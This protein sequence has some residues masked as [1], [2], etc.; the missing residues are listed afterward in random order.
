[1]KIL[2]LLFMAGLITA[3]NLTKTAGAEQK[4]SLV[5][6][7][8]QI[9]LGQGAFILKPTTVI[10]AGGSARPV[11]QYLADTLAPATGFNL[12]I[13]EVALQSGSQF[14]LLLDVA[15]LDRLGPEGYELKVM[16][17]TIFA[18]AP[19]PRGL[20]YA[21]QTIRQLL[22]PQILSQK[23]VDG[24]SWT[25]PVVEITDK[26]RYSWRGMHL[27]VGR[28]FFDVNFIKKYLDLIALHKM[29]TFHWHLTEDQGWR[30]EIK[31]YPKLTEIGAWREGEYGK[32]Y[33]DGKKYGGFY[34]QDEIREIVAYAQQRFITVVPEIEMPGHSVAALAAYPELSCTGG[35][36][37]V[38]ESW[39]VEED[40]FCAGNDKTFEFLENVLTEVTDLFP[41]LYLHIGGDECPKNRWKNC[42]QCQARIKNE[43]LKDEH[44]LQSYFIKRI[45][46]FLLTKNKRLIGWDEILEGGLAPTAT[47]MSWRGMGGGIAAA[48]QGHDV[49][50]S[51]TS[52]CYFDFYQADPAQEPKA[53]GGF[54]PLEKVYSFEPTPAQLTPEQAQHVLGAQGNVWTEYMLTT[55]YVEYMAAPRICALAEVVWSPQNLRNWDNFQLRLAPHLLR[56]DALDIHYRLPEPGGISGQNVFFNQITLTL[57]SPLPDAQ[58]RYTLDGSN[59]DKNSTLYTAPIRLTETTTVKAVTVMPTGRTSAVRSASYEK[60]TLHPARL[61]ANPQPGIEYE[62]FQGRIGKMDEWNK[63]NSTRKGAQPALTLPRDRDA[64]NFAVLLTGFIKIEKDGIYTFYTTSDD[65]STLYI[66]DTLVVDNDAAHAAQEKSGQ[67]ALAA[68]Y[69]PIRVKYFELDGDE[70]LSVAYEGPGL[71]KQNIPASVLFHQAD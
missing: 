67:I 57:Q 32:K 58:V 52:H 56:L 29:N 70:S 65:G 17:D 3:T 39:G 42:P 23:K 25:I 9:Q 13:K 11:G 21:C 46:K 34:T 26:P 36:F 6:Q 60:Q 61:L 20:F 30:V 41:G 53:I 10:V 15:A 7:P 62:Y 66:G 5:P 51:P 24:I 43:G 48:T 47:V 71:T 38:R 44:E 33:P 8:M 28:H 18:H 69:H 16:P 63:L 22:P 50:M 14:V 27:D 35:P 12:A 1:M 2:G 4:V 37:K 59:P 54:L 55:D 45:E 31:K 19:T 64:D 49:V 40:V 68:G